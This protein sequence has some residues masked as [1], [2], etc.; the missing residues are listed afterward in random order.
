MHSSG[1]RLINV[2]A[3]NSN[4]VAVRTNCYVSYGQGGPEE[5]LFKFP[6]VEG[7]SAHCAILGTGDKEAILR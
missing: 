3:C 4:P 6:A 1:Q 2:L 7:E 5:Y